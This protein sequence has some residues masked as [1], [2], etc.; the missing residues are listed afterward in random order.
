[1]KSRLVVRLYPTP[2]QEQA[3]E[4]MLLV[5]RRLWNA[6]LGQRRDAWKTR[7]LNI[8]SKRQYG[9]IT[10]LRKHDDWYAS[11]YRECEDAVL[12]R[13]DLAYRKFFDGGGHPRF[14]AAS[15]WSQF[16]FSHGDRAMRWCAGQDRITQGEATG[17]PDLDDLRS[18]LSPGDPRLTRH[19]V[20]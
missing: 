7:R 9:E 1:M 6:L 15:R 18:E 13:L 2:A 20:A 4:H 17:L 19:E 10:E 16:E 5:T 8:N 3:C 14:K 11:V 12:H